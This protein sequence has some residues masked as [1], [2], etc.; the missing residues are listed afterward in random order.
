MNPMPHH[1]V[2]RHELWRQ[3]DD[4][5][6]ARN[7]YIR[8]ALDEIA[9]DHRTSR[10]RMR[11]GRVSRGSMT[12]RCCGSSDAWREL[13]TDPTGTTSATHEAVTNSHFARP[14]P[15]KDAD[16]RRGRGELNSHVDPV[17]VID[18]G[19]RIVPP[20]PMRGAGDEWE[21]IAAG[22]RGPE[23]GPSLHARI[24]TRRP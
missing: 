17:Q 3:R 20:R 19:Q 15:I 2:A 23:G 14:L 10:A 4:V 18:S 21:S 6:C 24:A 11:R 5:C 12:S 1:F 13:L 8:R 16:E 9:Q 7:D 22:C